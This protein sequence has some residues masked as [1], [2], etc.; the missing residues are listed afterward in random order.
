MLALIFA[1]GLLASAVPSSAITGTHPVLVV[2]C[3]ASNETAEPEPPSYYEDMFSDRGSGKLGALDYWRDV[4]YGNL[5]VSGTVVKGW[6]TL[7]ITRDTWVASDRLTKWRTC[8]EAAKNDVD[9]NDYSGVIAVHL[10]AYGTLASGISATDTSLT[11]KS[12]EG[13]AANFPTPPFKAGLSDG[14]ASEAVKITA[15]SGATFTIERAQDGSTAASFPAGAT[16]QVGNE[17]FGLSPGQTLAGTKYDNLGGAVMSHDH[18]LDLALHEE[19]HSFG[20]YAP[21][22]TGHHSRTVSRWPNSEYCDQYDL[23]SV[24]CSFSWF[25]R[26]DFGG[27]GTGFARPPGL[28]AIQLDAQ[29]W[30]PA[31][32]ET[33]FDNSS[34]RQATYTMAA[35]NH[36]EKSGFQEIRIPASG[37]FPVANSQT[38]NTDYYTVELRSKSGWDRGIPGDGFVLHLKSSDGH[39][40]LVDWDRL[41][42]SVGTRDQNGNLVEPGALRPDSPSLTGRIYIDSTTNAYIAP[43]SIDNQAFTG[44]I[45][46]GSCPINANLTYSGDT[47]AVYHRQ[48]TL[49]GDL[50][51][52]GTQAPVPNVK[53]DFKL[54]S[55]SCSGTT[56]ASGHASCTITIDQPSGSYTVDASFA[57]N[58]AYNPANASAAFTIE[59]APTILTYTGPTVIL[60]GAS[61]VTLR[62]VL[63]EDAPNQPAPAPSGQTVTLGVGGQTCTGTVSSTGLVSCSLVFTGP[64]GEEP[65]TAVFAG[66]QYYLPSSDTGKTATVFAFPSKGAFMLGDTNVAT[67]TSSIRVTWWSHGWWLQNNLSG[68]IAP[69][70]FKGFAD[71]VS[72]LPTNSPV[73]VCG[74]RF[75]TSPGSSPRPPSGVPSYM[76]VLVASSAT[77]AGSAV[78][79]NWG[80]IVVV[81][82]DPGYAPNAGHPGTGTIVA[83]FCP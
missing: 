35:L 11:L 64:L 24:A 59:R 74:T 81:K 25:L 18:P 77:K 45:T 63:L 22:G 66:D 2:L 12:T 76:G 69:A 30:L 52:G 20:F 56:N 53:V 9:Y 23:G 6:Y 62:A 41:R 83:T 38:I 60:Q 75:K 57:G 54:G 14:S 39:S 31:A 49:A 51:V 73:T 78:E 4:S 80:K 55:Q 36:P 82:T 27:E 42:L 37:T 43:N 7:G 70:S 13:A 28:N 72:T 32:R 46:V 16:L 15:V 71:H 48:A 5:S 40:Y 17:L 26:D 79:G 19:A 34:C 67:A 33:T 47:T 50:K 3:K 44:V 68:G 65:I 29:G 1:A 21:L 8:A 58:A 61:G 10:N